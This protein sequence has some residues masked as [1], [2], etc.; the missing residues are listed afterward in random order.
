MSKRLRARLNRVRKLV[1]RLTLRFEV[2]ILE[3][4]HLVARI[5]DR[6]VEVGVSMSE[7]FRGPADGRAFGSAEVPFSRKHR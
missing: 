3:T 5:R 2:T 6:G 4:L 7:G 1:Q